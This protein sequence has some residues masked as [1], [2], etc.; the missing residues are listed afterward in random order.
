M[1]GSQTHLK[2]SKLKPQITGSLGLTVVVPLMG[3]CS[4]QRFAQQADLQH[5]LDV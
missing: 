3:S 4:L 1:V 2:T 5:K